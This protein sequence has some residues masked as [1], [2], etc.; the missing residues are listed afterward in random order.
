MTEARILSRRHVG[1]TLCLLALVLATVT[2]VNARGDDAK[3]EKKP[4]GPSLAL[5]TNPQFG[6]SP[7]RIVVSAELRGGSDTDPELY[8]PDVEWEW[9]DGTKSQASQN[10]PPFVAGESQIT[11]RWTVSHVYTTAGRYQM[12]LRLK[13]G[14]KVVLAGNAK[15]EIKPGLRDL[16]EYDQ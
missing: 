4:K 2:F 8:C 6:F 15:V 13:R 10:C 12:Y 16:S 5:K 14:S 9:G 7:A 1:F 11:R 3:D